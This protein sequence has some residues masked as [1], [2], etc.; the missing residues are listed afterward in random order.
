MQG[1]YLRD[2]A[3]VGAAGGTRLR[4]GSRNHQQAAVFFHGGQS[5][6]FEHGIKQL[7]HLVAVQGLI[8]MHRKAGLGPWVHDRGQSQDACNFG[9]YIHD[10][11]VFHGQHPG[12][13]P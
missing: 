3:H 10:V 2:Y 1:Q 9:S 5:P 8:R 7:A 6:A 13:G 11:G 12:I 4:V